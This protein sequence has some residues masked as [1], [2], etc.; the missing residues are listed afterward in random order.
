MKKYIIVL[1][2]FCIGIGCGGSNNE[3]DAGTKVAEEKKEARVEE[4]KEQSE[5]VNPD[6][7]KGLELVAQS[8]CLT[9]HKIEETLTGPAY[10]AVAERYEATEQVIDTLSDKIIKGGAGKWGPVPMSAHP[11]ISKEDATTMVKYILSLKK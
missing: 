4:A 7:Q 5:A 9:C 11:Q 1:S 2:I 8:D 3:P 6:Y 10:R